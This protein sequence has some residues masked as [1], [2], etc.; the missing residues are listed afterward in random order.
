MIFSTSLMAASWLRPLGAAQPTTQFSDKGLDLLA[1]GDFGTG[2]ASQVAVSKQM[3]AFAQKLDQPLTGVLA[4]G[5]NFY[6]KMEME[7]FGRHF[8]DMY[9]KEHLNCPF[10][11]CL[12]NHDYGPQYDSKQGRPKAQM[13]LDYAAQNPD[14][15]WRMPNRWYAVELPNAEKPLVKIIFLDGNMY[16]WGLTPREKMDQRNFLKAELAKKTK[17]PWRWIVSHYP[18]YTETTKRSDNQRLIK[19]WASEFGDNNI[20]FYLAGHDHNLQ[21]L[22]VDGHKTSF[23]VTGAGGANLYEVKASERGYTNMILGF[24]HLHVSKKAVTAQFINSD[25]TCL[26]A[27]RRTLNGKIKT[28]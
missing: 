23:V 27:F 11:A 24:T 12:G 20:S 19:E 21:H 2:N 8:E 18:L 6:G 16:E 1:I 4:L 3:S 7:R 22:K 5:D 28:L 15:R 13:Q 10:Y 14:S 25:G 9:S 17:A 26:H